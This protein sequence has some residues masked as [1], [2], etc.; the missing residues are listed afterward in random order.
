MEHPSWRKQ[1]ER[2]E[3][4]SQVLLEE[5]WNQESGLQKK[6]ECSGVMGTDETPSADFRAIRVFITCMSV[7][8]S[9]KGNLKGSSSEQYSHVNLSD[10]WDCFGHQV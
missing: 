6:A 4:N 5:V 8:G 3:D 7:V 1:I 9:G 10:T 2:Q